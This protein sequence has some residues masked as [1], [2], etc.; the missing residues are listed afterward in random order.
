MKSSVESL[1]GCLYAK[2][3]VEVEVTT[4]TLTGCNVII[5]ASSLGLL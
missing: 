2:T 5:E 1:S 4:G 3:L